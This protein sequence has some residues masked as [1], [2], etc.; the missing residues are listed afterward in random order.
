MQIPAGDDPA[1]IVDRAGAYYAAGF[2]EIILMLSGGSMSTAQDPVQ[3]AS[4][5][6]EKVLPE[7]EAARGGQAH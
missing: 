5:L 2:T 4:M 7:L 3:T 1:Q 6:A